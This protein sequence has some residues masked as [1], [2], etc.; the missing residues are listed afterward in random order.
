MNSTLSERELTRIEQDIYTR[1]SDAL[2]VEN[3]ALY[4]DRGGYGEVAFLVCRNTRAAREI[5]EDTP[6]LYEIRGNSLIVTV[7]HPDRD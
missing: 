5:V 1:I 4:E 7:R 2:C 6:A 3:I